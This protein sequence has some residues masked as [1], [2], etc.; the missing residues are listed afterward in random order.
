LIENVYDKDKLR[1]TIMAIPG[2][3]GYIASLAGTYLIPMMRDTG[4]WWK[5]ILVYLG[6]KE[7]ADIQLGSGEIFPLKKSNLS[8]L[9]AELETQTTLRKVKHSIS[10]G[11]VKMS[12][13]SIHVSSDR[14]SAEAIASAFITKHYGMID[15]KGRDV[16]DIGAYVG[17]GAVYYALEG[18]AN[19]VYAVEPVKSLADVAK[20]NAKLNRLDKKI[21]V[22]RVAIAGKKKGKVTIEDGFGFS[23]KGVPSETLDSLA[24]KHKIAH[25]A[26]KVDCEGCEYDIFKHVSSRTLKRFDVINVE[27]HHGYKDIV[28]RLRTEGYEVRYTKPRMSFTQLFKTSII[29]GDIIAVREGT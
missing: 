19:K 24:E 25:G 27:Y 5:V 18:G 10:N 6:V 12:F 7:N 23:E 9:I 15:V 14:S 21:D 22:I 13:G 3:A 26:L 28:E 4:D 29:S 2:A 1:L 11:V 20:K 16:V 17:D 8:E